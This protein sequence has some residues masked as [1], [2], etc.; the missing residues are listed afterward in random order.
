MLC[1]SDTASGCQE[2][3]DAYIPFGKD[4]LALY[5]ANTPMIQIIA[6]IA[7]QGWWKMTRL[8]D[9]DALNREIDKVECFSRDPYVTYMSEC[10]AN[11]PT[12]D[13]VPVEMIKSRIKDLKAMLMNIN[14]DELDEIWH[15]R[16][17]IQ[18]LIELL[19]MWA[20]RKEE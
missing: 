19:E 2:K 9:A 20:E 14:E 18:T 5:V 10:I 12:V 6:R 1:L 4:T 3:K 13:A 15:L 8:I 7:E 17:E 11:A 16:T